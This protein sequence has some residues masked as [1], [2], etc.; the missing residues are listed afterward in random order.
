VQACAPVSAALRPFTYTVGNGGRQA[1]PCVARRRPANL[2][3]ASPRTYGSCNPMF[4]GALRR[5]ATVRLCTPTKP[6]AQPVYGLSASGRMAPM[7]NDRNGRG[8]RW[9]EIVW[10]SWILLLAG[11]V[12]L[13]VAATAFAQ[14]RA[15]L[16]DPQS[17]LACWAIGVLT[18]V[19][20]C[21]P[22]FVNL[23]RPQK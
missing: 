11:G 16:T 17:G 15:R 23:R 9:Q 6:P 19:I 3:E 22:A 10:Y 18:A 5:P 7:R 12:H 8:G 14:R 13:S 21:L 20:V 2:L 1:H 4:G